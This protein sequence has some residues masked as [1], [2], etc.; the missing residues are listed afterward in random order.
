MT[1]DVTLADIEASNCYFGFLL[2]SDDQ[3]SAELIVWHTGVF[4]C[5]CV[6]VRTRACVRHSLCTCGDCLKKSLS[7]ERSGDKLQLD[8]P[9]RSKQARRELVRA[10]ATPLQLPHCAVKKCAA[11]LSRAV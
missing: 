8:V 1:E 7:V 5:V 3:L 9:S 4:V 10:P 11:L 6:C 2:A